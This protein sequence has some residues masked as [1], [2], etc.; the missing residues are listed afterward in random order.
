MKTAMKTNRKNKVKTVAS[1]VAITLV[2]LAAFVHT[3]EANAWGGRLFCGRRACQSYS[4]CQYSRCSYRCAT[5]SA[6]CKACSNYKSRS[7]CSGD[8]CSV[9][10]VSDAPKYALETPNNCATCFGK[11]CSTC[12]TNVCVDC[13]LSEI[14]RE[15]IAEANRVRG[16]FV[17]KFDATVNARSQYNSQCQAERRQLGHFTGDANEIA[18]MGYASAKAAI[19]GWLN[20]P[21]HR[22]ILLRSNYTKVGASVKRGSNG[23]LYWTMNFGY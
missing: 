8:S 11:T 18:G 3:S 20:S 22:A 1:I 14:E 10:T 6:S 23:V 9:N 13:D 19:Q 17:L 15:L 5:T 12:A 16:R 7:V 4:Y 2:T 21:A